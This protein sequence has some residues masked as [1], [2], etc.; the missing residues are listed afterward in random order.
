MKRRIG[1]LIWPI[2][3]SVGA[4]AMNRRAERVAHGSPSFM[5]TS[6]T[7]AESA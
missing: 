1:P 2:G 7:T 5:G 3:Q 6:A 4:E